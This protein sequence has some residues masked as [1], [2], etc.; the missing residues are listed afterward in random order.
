MPPCLIVFSRDK[1]ESGYK[2]YEIK[3]GSYGM[4]SVLLTVN[5]PSGVIEV[6][7]YL[8]FLKVVERLFFC[9]NE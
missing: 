9:L 8:S 5:L 2:S 3:N 7:V 1:F 6:N 4:D